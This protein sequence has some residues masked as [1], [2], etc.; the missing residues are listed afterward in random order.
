LP[1]LSSGSLGSRD[2]SDYHRHLSQKPVS[3]INRQIS[4][5]GFLNFRG[6]E[7]RSAGGVQSCAEEY[8]TPVICCLRFGAT[9]EWRLGD[10]AASEAM[11]ALEPLRK[12]A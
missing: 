11:I 7:I 1:F 12:K 5:R 3:R 2:T 10:I 9:S 6:V 8:H 4:F